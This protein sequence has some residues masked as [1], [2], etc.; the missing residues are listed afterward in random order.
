MDRREDLRVDKRDL[1]AADTV[2][3]GVKFAIVV[4]NHEPL[5]VGRNQ[6]KDFEVETMVRFRCRRI[7]HLIAARDIN[8]VSL[9]ALSV[10]VKCAGL[11]GVDECL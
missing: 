7:F 3:D 2:D 11:E 4:Q 8:F 1:F 6:C 9:I 5:T 10:V